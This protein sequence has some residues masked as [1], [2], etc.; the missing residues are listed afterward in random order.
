MKINSTT[1]NLAIVAAI[2]FGVFLLISSFD[3]NKKESKTA[4]QTLDEDN[5]GPQYFSVKV[6][7][8]ID[9]AGEQVPTHI[10]DVKERLE[11]ELL[12]TAYRHSNTF[13]LLKKQTRWFPVIEQILRE[14]GVPDDF[15]Y[16]CVAESGMAQV[17][18]P[19]RAVGFW[20]FLERTGKEYG[21]EINSEVDER[22]HVEKS[23]RAACQYLKQAKARFGSWTDAAASYN[24]G[25]AGL[26]NQMTRQGESN[27][28]DILLNSETSR[29]VFRILAFKEVLSNPQQYGFMLDYQDQYQP[30]QYKEVFVD[31]SIDDF[32]TFA[33]QYNTNYKTLK[34]LNPWLRDKSLTVQKNTY[35]I[36][37]PL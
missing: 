35:M 14:E 6:P 26:N 17:V 22:Y 19:A 28:Y 11:R 24:M 33:K 2:L 5:L 12:V 31:Y 20:Q 13:L 23:T 15:K 29:Y 16:L 8:Y 4:Y 1:R 3:N 36:K 30:Y 25:M 37:V 34:I 10:P 9:F 21:L 32:A 7:S 18:S 27:Y